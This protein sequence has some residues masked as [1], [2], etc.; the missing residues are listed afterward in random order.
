MPSELRILIGLVYMAIASAV[1]AVL[2]VLLM[3]W[4]NLRIRSCNYWGWVT[5][6]FCTWLSGSRV[7]FEGWEHLDGDRPAIYVSNHTSILDIFLGIWLG[8]VGVVGVAK[9]EVVYYP[10]FGQLYWLSGHLRLDRGDH[11]KAMAAMRELERI[12]KAYRLSIWMWPEGTR[13]KDGRLRPFKK[14]VWHL[15]VA[16]GL[17]VVPVVVAGAQ[18]VWPKGTTR[19]QSADVHVTILPAIDTS[20]WSAR[21]ADEVVDELHALFLEHLPADQHPLAQAA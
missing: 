2:L 21:D 16:T 7:S 4:R 8:P 9:K 13:S 19:L 3:P 20:G 1:Q 17:P 6:R 15:A 18:R 11:G 12:V 5:G 14:G 10:F